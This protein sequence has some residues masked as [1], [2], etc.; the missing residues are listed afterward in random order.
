MPDM[1]N[2]NTPIYNA[3]KKYIDLNPL[4]FHMPG[5]K[6]GK[7]IPPEVLK[8]L[9][10]MDITEIPGMD[11]LHYPQ[12]I[13]KEAQALASEAFG[14]DNTF[15]LVNG[16]TS[17]IHAM[18][19]ALCN[20][21]DQLIVPRDCHKSVISGM[22]LAG[23]E[24]VYLHPEFNQEFGITTVITPHEVEKALTNN[25]GAAAVLITRPNY[26]GVCSDIEKIAEI[27]HRHGKILAV[28]EAHG[29]HLKFGEG[30]PLCAI[31]GG[32]DI[33][34]QS[35]HKTLPALT[36][37]SYLHVKGERINLER[38]KM[39]LRMLQTSSPSYP[40]MAMLDVA[41][42]IMQC[43]G[44]TLISKLLG[45]IE[46]LRKQ[47][48]K[49]DKNKYFRWL[50]GKDIPGGEK[51][52]TR[53]VINVRNLGITGYEADRFLRE[54]YN[55]FAEMSDLYNV[56]FI[57]TIADTGES[58]DRLKEGLLR[59]LDYS[60]KDRE[61]ARA[62]AKVN[63][64]KKYEVNKIIKG[65]INNINNKAPNT[66][67][68]IGLNMGLPGIIIKEPGIPE[69]VMKLKDILY[70]TGTRVFLDEAEGR[71][72]KEIITPYPPGIP[73]VCPGEVIT[74]E[75]IA[76]IHELIS[77]GC[78]VNGVGEEMDVLVVDDKE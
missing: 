3:V 62:K 71:I 58:F 70:T 66:I 45:N 49:E 51:D 56:V 7:G 25:P 34:V 11:N 44:K 16:S 78:Q 20:P 6:L 57:A 77:N 27:V 33:C 38:L 12:G 5:H 43:Y 35:A 24:P 60:I 63:E 17:G 54:K 19:M 8:N 2:L 30:L 42:E 73:L 55:I 32:A 21:G 31:E 59:L 75:I 68:N 50:T 72:S 10:F 36:Q 4:P 40:I 69:Q 14:S 65:R 67:K 26:Y 61:R 28:D 39:I 52:P 47:I 29:A 23:V 46:L 37:G 1:H 9:P 41:R 76:Y 15:F 18:I 53:I 22:M 13:I 48:E 74:R 64:D